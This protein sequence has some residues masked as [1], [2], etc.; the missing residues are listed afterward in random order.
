MPASAHIDADTLHGY[1]PAGGVRPA[2]ASHLPRICLE[3]VADGYTDGG[4]ML[5][6]CVHM[7]DERVGRVQ[8]DLQPSALYFGST[9]KPRIPYSKYPG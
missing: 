6:S 1:V 4:R 2:V 5:D 7:D 3:Q 8:Q 9:P